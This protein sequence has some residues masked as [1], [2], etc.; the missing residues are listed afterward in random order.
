[1]KRPFPNSN[2]VFSR[3]GAISFLIGV[4]VLGGCGPTGNEDE[5][6]SEATESTLEITQRS[7]VSSPSATSTDQSSSTP[8]PDG[9]ARSETGTP[10]TGPG[11]AVGNATPGSAGSPS[12]P[13][14]VPSRQRPAQPS[15]EEATAGG[16]ETAPAPGEG[17]A[18]GDGTTGAVPTRDAGTP[19]DDVSADSDGA[20]Q[21]AI[22]DSCEP[23]DVPEFTGDADAFV[24][25]ENLNFRTGPGVDCDPIGDSLLEVGTE[26]TATSDPVL[27]DG[28]DTEWVRVEFE[29]QEGWVAADFI[30]PEAE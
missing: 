2:R 3:M 24:V 29:G 28:E 22:V 11:N 5:A 1:M 15:D 17:S 19:S 13:T 21:T 30:E 20:S 27:R 8:T 16:E 14:P 7:T 23:E 10:E 4:L 25:V 26:L 9:R 6:T 18:T 12:G